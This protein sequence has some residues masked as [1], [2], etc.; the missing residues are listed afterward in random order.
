MDSWNFCDEAGNLLTEGW[1][2]TAG[3]A[4]ALAERKASETG[5][6]VEYWIC[7]DTRGV[8]DDGEPGPIVYVATPEGVDEEPS[9]MS[10]EEA[11]AWAR[12]AEAGDY[13]HEWED[14]GLDEVSDPGS[15]GGY[16]D[17]TLDSVEDV[18]RERD[19][20]LRADDCGLVVEVRS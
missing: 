5:S 15:R 16:D 8:D 9:R 14:D 6:T 2:G 7:G 10:R 4:A 17:E 20:T 13:L 3:Q 12:E 1:H 18:L 19:L 11:L